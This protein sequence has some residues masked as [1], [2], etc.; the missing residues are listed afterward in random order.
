MHAN[1]WAAEDV[2]RHK[3]TEDLKRRRRDAHP[4]NNC[5]AAY[6]EPSETED[7]TP[8]PQLTPETEG[9]VK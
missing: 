3:Q 5:D 2:E 6:D 7:D 8:F 4:Q 9:G 1:D